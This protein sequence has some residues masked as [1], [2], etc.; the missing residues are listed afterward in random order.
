MLADIIEAP[1]RQTHVMQ[2]TFRCTLTALSEPLRPISLPVIPA[3]EGIDPGLWALI[4]TI[5]DQDV[6]V[7]W[8][9]MTDSMRSNVLFHTGVQIAE[10]PEVADWLIL[11]ASD[12]DLESI[13]DKVSLGTHERPDTAASVVFLTTGDSTDVLAEGPGF[14]HPQELKIELSEALVYR[15]IQN[16]QRYPLGFDSM[17]IREQTLTG[18]PRSTRLMVRTD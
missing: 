4:L 15:L 7:Y 5:L 16:N 13:L 10:T 17:L 12:P 11:G 14:K 3:P 1:A 6:S 9:H 2:Q 8:P 18:L